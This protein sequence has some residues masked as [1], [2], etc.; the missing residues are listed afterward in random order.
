MTPWSPTSLASS[1]KKHASLIRQMT[2]REV[3]GRYRG[4]WLGLAWS[5]FNPLLMLSIY[6]FVFSVVFQAR[7]G[8]NSQESKADFAIILFVGLIVHAMFAELINRAPSLV[9]ANPSYV[10]KVVFPLETLPWVAAGSSF[11]HA[12]VS[13]FVLILLQLF[14]NHHLPWTALVFPVVLFPLIPISI[15][16]S[17]GLAALGV[18]VRDISQVTVMLTTVLFFVSP[19]IYPVSGVPEE[20]RSWLRL[21]P[22]TFFVEEGRNTLLFGVLPDPINLAIA[23]VAAIVVVWAGYAIFQKARRGFAD[24]L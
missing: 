17:Y 19:I 6:T 11:F 1:L 4:S 10:K 21:S 9:T 24:V 14:T 22:L 5:F 3:V 12:V 18:F 16:L 15:G 2:W 13:I 23:Y 8:T 20:F 7:W